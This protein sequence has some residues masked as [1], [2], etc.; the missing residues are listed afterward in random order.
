M[1]DGVEEHGP[2]HDTL[3]FGR[4]YEKHND[5]MMRIIRGIRRAYALLTVLAATALLA[6]AACRQE[7]ERG[8]DRERIDF[9]LKD[10]F[11]SNPALDSAVAVTFSSMTRPERAG[12]MIVAAAG[13]LGKP[14][15]AIARMIRQQA[16]GGV[17]LLNGSME[18]FSE[19][20]QYFDSL[21]ATY[22]AAPLIF[23]ADAEPSLVN[24]KIAG[25]GRVPV[26]SEISS[27][28][29]SAR[30]AK[31]IARDLIAVG[32]QHS[33]APVV[34]LSQSNAAITNR[35]F[36]HDPDV[37]ASRA[38]AYIQ[39]TQAEGIIATAK[40]FPGHG[41][42]SGDTHEKLVY[43]DGPMVEVP[44][45]R[46]LIDV[47]VLSIMVGHIAVRNNAFETGGLPASC[48]RVIVRDLLRD[49]LNFE[50]LVVTDALNMGA[51][52]ALD[53][54]PM[55]AVEAGCD[56]ILMPPDETAFRDA[57]VRR[58]NRD[59]EFEKQVDRAVQ[60]IIRAKWCLGLY[61]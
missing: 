20:V 7:D 57:M 13:R 27:D 54:A 60:R 18:G 30:I 31:A 48:A 59:P 25:S 16:I 24:R 22:G 14:D 47:G 17:L 40:H 32:I 35:S 53:D 38:I 43:I 58:M 11:S 46:P 42:V 51:V 39:A 23:S 19:K 12:Q 15:T 33:Y 29:M 34:D 10:F 52:S 4:S 3:I 44:G 49:S 37:V 26:T 8:Q 36:G 6:W 2:G 5:C 45:Y 41:L 56:V 61:D 55:H 1:V 50:G 9:S 28:S 21:S